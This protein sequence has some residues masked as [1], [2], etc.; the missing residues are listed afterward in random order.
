MGWF[1]GP[2]ATLSL[3]ES[4]GH[5]GYDIG[6]L[7]RLPYTLLRPDSERQP[8]R[9]EPHPPRALLLKRLRTY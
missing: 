5:K 6:S 9:F 8:T 2:P 1:L 7:P 3:L 4:N